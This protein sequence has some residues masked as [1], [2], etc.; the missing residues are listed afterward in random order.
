[1]KK[2]ELRIEEEQVRAKKFLDPS[3]LEKVK[4]E[5]DSVL[6][7]KHK[8]LLQVECENYLRDDKQEGN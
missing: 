4:R 7:E 8:E 1:M 2:A 5:V 3:S 6:I